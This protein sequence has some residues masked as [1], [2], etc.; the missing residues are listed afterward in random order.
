MSKDNHASHDFEAKRLDGSSVRTIDYKREI[1]FHR[2]KDEIVELISTDDI[3]L[4]ISGKFD[5][6]Y[7]FARHESLVLI[8]EEYR[9]GHQ[10]P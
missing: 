7:N 8:D 3:L 1:L 6:Q 9:C 4:T 5:W 2:S 10:N